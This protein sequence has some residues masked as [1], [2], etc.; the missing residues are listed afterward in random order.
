MK[1]VKVQEAS[2]QNKRTELPAV[3]QLPSSTRPST[4]GGPARV[5]RSKPAAAP[6]V[7][8]AQD[9]RD[10]LVKDLTTNT[11]LQHLRPGPPPHRS[12]GIDV[13]D[14]V[15]E[16]SHRPVE[17]AVDGLVVILLV[18]GLDNQLHRVAQSSRVHDS[19]CA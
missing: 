18:W 5:S 12:A 11:L 9:R 17:G 15:L 19:R 6:H 3:L 7:A 4:A 2:S 8:A 1:H 16:S 10:K 13:S 14:V